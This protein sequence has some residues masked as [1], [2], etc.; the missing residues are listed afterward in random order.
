[1]VCDSFVLSL[2]CNM[3]R[4][5]IIKTISLNKK[6]SKH[7]EKCTHNFK[8]IPS[9]KSAEKFKVVALILKDNVQV[10]KR[11]S[12]GSVG[13][14]TISAIEKDYLDYFFDKPTTTIPSDATKPSHAIVCCDPNTSSSGDSS[15]M[16]LFATTHVQGQRVVSILFIIVFRFLRNIP[17]ELY[18]VHRPSQNMLSSV[19]LYIRKLCG[20]WIDSVW[21]LV[22]G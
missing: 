6:H 13:D 9:W 7:P 5:V 20:A 22:W 12:M 4:T 18:P 8:Y 10:L 17:G 3:C 1:M 14:E 15:E 2:I 19:F 11:E 21:F 16:A